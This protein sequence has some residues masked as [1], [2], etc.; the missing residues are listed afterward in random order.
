MEIP[1]KL[2]NKIKSFL[3]E[4]GTRTSDSYLVNMAF[5]ISEELS[6]VCN[7]DFIIINDTSIL[8][9]HALKWKEMIENGHKIDSVKEIRCIH[10]IGLRESKKIADKI[11]EMKALF[12]C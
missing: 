8:K 7:H 1:L 5:E 6:L 3:R 11:E 12:L 2:Y 10:D 4:V 9:N